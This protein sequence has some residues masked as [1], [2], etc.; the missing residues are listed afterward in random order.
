MVEWILETIMLLQ[1][2]GR[3]SLHKM[4]G[5]SDDGLRN[6]NGSPWYPRTADRVRRLRCR[7]AYLS[8]QKKA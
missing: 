7:A 1:G 8:G 5:G 4:G 6:R 3:P 2:V